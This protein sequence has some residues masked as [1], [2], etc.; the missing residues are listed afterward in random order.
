LVFLFRSLAQAQQRTKYPKPTPISFI[1]PPMD[2]SSLAS[3]NSLS[4]SR[5]GSAWDLP[6]YSS[7]TPPLQHTTH[8]L[9]IS[10]WQLSGKY[11]FRCLNL[12]W[13]DTTIALLCFGSAVPYMVWAA[14]AGN[15]ATLA[16]GV[17]PFPAWVTYLEGADT[18]VIGVC[19]IFYTR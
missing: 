9:P 2:S 14:Y 13:I 6:T 12:L 5:K 3:F 17:L 16:K 15:Y 8:S 4:L 19:M 7:T 1:H 11:F 18:L 10:V